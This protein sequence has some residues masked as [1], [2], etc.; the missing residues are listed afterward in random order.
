MIAEL[1]SIASEWKESNSDE[2]L[3]SRR[4]VPIGCSLDLYGMR[5]EYRGVNE[6]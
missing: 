5:T 4:D 3:R 2:I 6:M 1:F